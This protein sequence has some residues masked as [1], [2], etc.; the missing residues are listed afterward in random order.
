M[1]NFGTMK[2][3]SVRSS[4]L[5]QIIRDVSSMEVMSKLSWILH[6]NKGRYF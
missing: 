3:I 4:L 2:K 1:N 5:I 6:T